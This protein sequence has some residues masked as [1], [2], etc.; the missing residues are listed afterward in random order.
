VSVVIANSKK[1]EKKILSDL[2]N[3]GRIEL[4]EVSKEVATKGN[5]RIIDGKYAVPKERESILRR[6]KETDFEE[7]A[8]NLK[9]NPILFRVERLLAYFLRKL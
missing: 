6:L 3:L 1:G 8:N 7:I 9:P 5:P 4:V 2:L